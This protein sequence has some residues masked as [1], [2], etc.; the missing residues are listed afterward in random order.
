MALRNRNGPMV[1]PF[2]LILVSAV[3]GSAL[4][5]LEWLSRMVIIA[6]ARE[7]QQLL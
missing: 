6:F 3:V 5:R 4:A 2:C 7:V 1:G